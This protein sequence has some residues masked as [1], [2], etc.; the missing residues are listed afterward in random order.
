MKIFEPITIK[1]IEFKNRVVM[2]LMVAFGLS[3]GDG[4]MGMDLIQ[5]YL[6][7]AGTGIGL[8]I[9]QY[10]AITKDRTIE[11]VGVYSDSQIDDLRTI[12]TACHDNNTRFFVQ[13][14][15]PHFDY[16]N[17]DTIND[18]LISD[19]EEI[20]REFINSAKRCFEADCDGIELHGA[21]GFFLNMFSSA[22]ANK[23]TDQY[24]GYL[25]GRLRLAKNIVKGIKKFNNDNFILSYRMGWNESL[26]DDIEMA[27]MLEKL[28]VEMLHVS[29]GIPSDRKI[30]VPYVFPCNDVVYTGTQIKAHVSIPVIA[31]NDIETVKTGNYLIENNLSDFVAY[32]KPFLADENFMVKSLDNIDYKPC[33]KC[34]NCKWFINGKRCPVQIKLNNIIKK[35]VNNYGFFT[36]S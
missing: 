1:N 30:S 11:G 3:N 31:V 8:M 36:T 18:L 20:E 29:T 7:R 33:L 34:K 35:E 10:H 32:G 4:T 23:R 17:G 24:G 6:K 27:Q 15:Y 21:H 25:K 12:A 13:L 22:L 28:G 9:C 19:L 26:E 5:H 14:E 2:T 16:K